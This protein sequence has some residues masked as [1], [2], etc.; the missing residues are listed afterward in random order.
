MVMSKMSGNVLISGSRIGFTKEQVFKVLDKHIDEDI[1]IV[2][3]GASGVDAFAQEW[4]I[5]NNKPSKI[6]RPKNPSNKIDYL[7]RNCI[8]IGMCSHYIIFWN[9]E[10]R[11]TKFTLEYAKYYGLTGELYN[12]R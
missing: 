12:H 8:M 2:H 5:R 4:C 3:G 11:G 1:I 10:S 6:I 7:Y 9:G